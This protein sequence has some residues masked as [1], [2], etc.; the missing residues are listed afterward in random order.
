MAGNESFGVPTR[1][2]ADAMAGADAVQQRPTPP[3]VFERAREVVRSGA[4]LD[5]GAL[6][7]D[8]GIS[9]PTLYRWTGDRE[10]LLADVSWAEV[11]LLLRYFDA[12]TKA[13]G[14]E[15]I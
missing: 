13:K 10:R 12:R 15:H 6:A 8:V 1:A 3:A 7:A 11:E 14:V 2:F 9:R 4:R 5:M